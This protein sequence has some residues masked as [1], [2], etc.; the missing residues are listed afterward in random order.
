[1]SPVSVSPPFKD[2]RVFF[3]SGE[4]RMFHLKSGE[5]IFPHCNITLRLCCMMI[6]TVKRANNPVKTPI[7]I[8]PMK[9]TGL[10][11]RSL[12]GNILTCFWLECT[13]TRPQSTQSLGSEATLLACKQ[14]VISESVC[15][16]ILYMAIRHL[17][18]IHYLPWATEKWHLPVSCCHF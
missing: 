3:A 6:R 1:M 14:G 16:L 18:N 10:S 12:L 11:G 17:K 8:L 7:P 5:E 2:I 9:N 15:A 4:L 13:K